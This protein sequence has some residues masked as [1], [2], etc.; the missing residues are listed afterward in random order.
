MSKIAKYL[1]EHILGEVIT[2]NSA[3]EHFSKDASILSITPE[4]IVNPRN[5]NDIRK[6]ARF[7]WQLAEKGHIVPITLRGGG[8]DQTGAAIG[9]GIIINTLAH[10]NNIFQVD[11]KSKEQ[12]VHVQPGVKFSA[13]N[14]TLLTHGMTIPATPASAEYSTVGGAVANN[15]GGKYAGCHGIIGNYVSRLEVVLANGDLIETGRISKR[16]LSKKKGLQTLEGDIYRKIDAL[17]EDNEKLI[18]E[19]IK[20]NNDNVGYSGISDVKNKDGSFDLTPLFVGSQGTLGL[21]SELVLNTELANENQSI[22]VASFKDA[23]VAHDAADLLMKLAPSVIEVIDGELFN[24]ASESG[25]KYPFT[26]GEDEIQ[27]ILYVS[28]N[29]STEH[30]TNKDVKKAI[31]KLSKLDTAIFTSSNYS[32]EELELVR[33]VS[34]I[35]LQTCEKDFSIPPILNNSSVDSTRR[36]EFTI[37]LKE[38]GKKHHIN[39]PTQI[40]WISG[41]INVYPKLNLHSVGDKQKSLKIIADYVD[42]IAKFDGSMLAQSSEGRLKSTIIYSR[43][44]P[45]ILKLYQEIR[46]IFDQFNTLNPG[47]KQETDL[48][49]LISN[50]NAD[51]SVSEITSNSINY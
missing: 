20:D 6:V 13:L 9:N 36:E 43:L 23:R 47:V 46:T 37:E 33:E 50:L 31:K 10:L 17:I 1:N 16:E 22:I 2:S 51:Y 32:V 38:L 15:A 30:S 28:F 27:S 21:I 40:D 14:K 35:V 45:K 24:I 44:D 4:L 19:E 25:K 42:L 41:V 8:T 3:R 18:S 12:I 39:L 29:S 11:S 49:S 34:S 7:T 48:K 26:G 5:T